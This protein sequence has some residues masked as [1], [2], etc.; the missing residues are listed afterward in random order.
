MDRS[1]WCFFSPLFFFRFSLELVDSRSFFI[2]FLSHMW[3]CLA[4]FFLSLPSICKQECS[5][6]SFR[7]H[8][9][10]RHRQC[11]LHCTSLFFLS[12]WT[13]SS[14]F[15]QVIIHV[16]VHDYDYDPTIF[17]CCCC[18]LFFFL[19]LFHPCYFINCFRIII[20]SLH[21]HLVSSFSSTH[22]LLRRSTHTHTHGWFLV[23]IYDISRLCASLNVFGSISLLTTTTTTTTT[24]IY[25]ISAT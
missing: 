2:F 6:V 10:L 18:C 1:W 22:C 19:F 17:S 24:A 16:H 5:S 21:V 3:S 4:I 23:C 13:P 25:T 20:F 12:H 14:Y 8:D 11:Q 15:L 9:R 7:L